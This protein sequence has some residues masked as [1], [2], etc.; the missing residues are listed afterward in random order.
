MEKGKTK[1]WDSAEFL[2][3]EKEVAAY[4]N[5]CFEEYSNDPTMIAH[6]FGV[7]ARARS[8]KKPAS[9]AKAFTRR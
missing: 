8:P 3:S 4:L 2:T 7:V 1:K 5:A 6:A 9:R